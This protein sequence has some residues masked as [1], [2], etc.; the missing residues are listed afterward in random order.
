MNGLM[1]R[2]EIVNLTMISWLFASSTIESIDPIAWARPSGSSIRVWKYSF[3]ADYSDQTHHGDSQ[4]PIGNAGDGGVIQ[5]DDDNERTLA[6]G[7]EEQKEDEEEEKNKRQRRLAVLLDVVRIVFWR[8]WSFPANGPAELL[9]VDNR[10]T[11]TS[12][13]TGHESTRNPRLRLK[14]KEEEK[15]QKNAAAT[16]EVEEELVAEEKSST[17]DREVVQ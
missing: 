1:S 4:F 16:V 14:C 2:L 17:A 12:A 11:G 3:Y 15:G 8:R 7:P 5:E 9:P 6:A 10:S 13:T